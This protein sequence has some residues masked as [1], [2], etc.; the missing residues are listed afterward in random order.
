MIAAQS[1]IVTYWRGIIGTLAQRG[2]L[3]ERRDGQKIIPQAVGL[4]EA[5]RVTFVLDM[6]RLAGVRREQWLDADLWAQWRAALQGRRCFV[7]DGAGLAIVVGRD[8]GA[9]VQRLPVKVSLDLSA[10]PE[11]DFTAYVGEGT[12]G[13]VVFNLADG[14]R[15][16]LVG[17]TT[18]SGKTTAI[19]SLILQLASKCGP[20]ALAL[21][22]V[23]LKRLDLVVLD[24]LPHLVRPVATTEQDAAD[25]VAWAVSEMER[26]FDVM[27]AAGVRR[28]DRLP[29]DDRFPLL[30]VVVD[31]CADFAKSDVVAD[32]VKLARKGR[33]AGVSLILATQRPDAEVLNRQIKANVTARLAFRCTDQVE[34]RIIL[35]R[36]GAEQLRRV[37]LALTNAGG[38]WRKVQVAYVP[39]G[40]MGEWVVVNPTPRPAL[41]EVER[42]LVRY[43]LQELDGAFTIGPLYDVHRG[44]ISKYALTNL[45]QDWE[46]RGWLTEPG[47]TEDGHKIGRQVTSELASL[48]LDGENLTS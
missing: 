24:A 33:A 29:V 26:R 36:T 9:G 38:T 3:R 31:E 1:E 40:T 11:G 34:S 47:R 10:V 18:G 23:D 16:L 30:L 17:G 28:W 39:D 4:V 35:D 32:L 7:A 14:E 27:S 44:D 25:M 43:A 15:A 48:A 12:T 41:S 21:A 5:Q 46:R 6:Q 8:P 45:A 19:L 22:A 20:D 42:A 37:G 2:L 13:P